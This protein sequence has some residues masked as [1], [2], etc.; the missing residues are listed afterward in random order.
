MPQEEIHVTSDLGNLARIAQF[1]SERALEAGFTE[2][3][4]FDI[5]M[6]VDEACTNVMEHAYGGRPD[7]QVCVSCHLESD[8]FVVCVC[9]SGAPFD[10]ASVPD[11]DVSSPLEERAIG[12]LG[13][14]FMQKLMDAVEFSSDP[15]EG[16]RVTMRKIRRGEA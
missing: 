2:S 11:P 10:P 4:V 8:D 3:Q 6:A 9:D 15:I 14:F 12:G 5:Q 1:V 13:L 7:G 16:N